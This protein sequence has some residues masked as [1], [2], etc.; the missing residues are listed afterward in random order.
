MSERENFLARWS[1][2]KRE[3]EKEDEAALTSL[4]QE[5]KPEGSPVDTPG[6]V[7]G[8]SALSEDSAPSDAAVDLTRLPP[9]E[10]ILAGTDIRAFLRSGVPVELTNAA[11]RRSWLADPTIR[12]FVG[13]AENQWDF[14]DPSA[15]PGFA[16][17]AATDEVRQLVDKVWEKQVKFPDAERAAKV[18]AP[19][20]SEGRSMPAKPVAESGQDTKL[21]SDNR[22]AIAEAETP[23]KCTEKAVGTAEE[24][25]VLVAK[26]RRPRNRRTHGTALPE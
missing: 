18:E 21:S 16:S 14:T 25:S 10:S 24:N 11:L 5:P 15:V 8:P 20:P 3:A 12:D 9:I 22:K 2:R 4:A 19:A 17:L 6:R 13:I 23:G 1:R 7:G 26:E